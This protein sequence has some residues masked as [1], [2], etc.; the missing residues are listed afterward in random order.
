[1]L[2]SVPPVELEEPIVVPEPTPPAKSKTPSP[3][4]APVPVAET[5]K[6]RQQKFKKSKGRPIET[7]E[8]AT[9]TAGVGNPEVNIEPPEKKQQL[10]SAELATPPSPIEVN[11]SAAVEA[12]SIEP[13]PAAVKTIEISAPVESS[14]APVEPTDPA[15][16]PV[17]QT[18]PVV[19]SQSMGAAATVEISPPVV[20][21]EAVPAPT[22]GEAEPVDAPKKSKKDKKGRTRDQRGSDESSP[23]HPK[24]EKKGRGKKG[25]PSAE[26]MDVDPV[27]DDQ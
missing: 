16:A 6:L 21:E 26:P 7:T 5:P 22:L 15:V 27:A 14:P 2:I 23:E 12:V 19:E 1:M 24:K 8:G 3:A 10:D 18:E 11:A 13:S 4:P 20:A 25:S 9:E 17:A